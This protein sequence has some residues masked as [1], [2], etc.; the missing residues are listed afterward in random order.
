MFLEGTMDFIIIIIMCGTEPYS[1]DLF[2][3][4]RIL[5]RAY[6]ESLESIMV[7]TV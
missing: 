6:S 5:K 1:L 7:S 3:K 4:L 2:L